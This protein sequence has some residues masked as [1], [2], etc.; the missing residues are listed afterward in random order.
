MRLNCIPGTNLRPSEKLRT[1][2]LGLEFN[3]PIGLGPGIDNYG[4]LISNLGSLGF[5]YVEI[6]P[7]SDEIENSTVKPEFIQEGN[8]IVIKTNENMTSVL[9]SFGYVQ[10]EILKFI[11][12]NKHRNLSL[13]TNIKISNKSASSVPYLADSIFCEMV[14]MSSPLSDFI[15]INLS[16]YRIKSLSQYKNI[17]KLEQLMVRLKKEYEYEIGLKSVFEHEKLL[18]KINGKKEKVIDK[19]SYP[20]H[21]FKK[22]RSRIMLRLDPNLSEDEI[23]GVIEISKKVGIVDGLV[24]GGM[25]QGNSSFLTGEKCKD[26]SL[27][28]LKKCKKYSKGDLALISTGG[29][30]NADDIYERLKYGAD[31]VLIYSPFILNGPFCLEK[32][33]TDLDSLMTRNGN[34]S[35]DEI[36]LS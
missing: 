18:N 30:M 25:L 7:L 15:T 1:N 28:I 22:G 2:L 31:F 33:V 3:H 26:R 16:S 13:A 12:F 8:G 19:F 21:L 35:I 34:K 4:N 5:E 14:K 24:I 23:K 36:R 27:D 11:K 17:T 9:Q 29:I 6:G 20:V 10:S 32:M